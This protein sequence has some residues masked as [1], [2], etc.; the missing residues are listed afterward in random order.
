MKTSLLKKISKKYDGPKY[1]YNLNEISHSYSSLKKS[2]PTFSKLYYSMKANPNEGVVNYLH[3]LGAGIE[4]SSWGEISK[5]LKSGVNKK[6]IIFTGPAKK[7][8][9]LVQFI[10]KKTGIISIE[11]LNEFK[12]VS[13]LSKKLN[14]NI[15]CIIRINPENIDIKSSIKM[16]GVSS[17]F[18][19]D[20]KKFLQ[21]YKLF[22][23]SKTNILGFHFYSASNVISSKDLLKMFFNCIDLSLKIEKLLKIKI[24]LLNLGGGF[25]SPYGKKGKRKNYSTIKKPLETKLINS[26]GEERIKSLN[27]I[28][29]SGRYLVGT[30]GGL[31]CKVIDKKISKNKKY[32]ILDSGINNLAGMSSINRLPKLDPDIV[33]INRKE[34]KKETFDIVGP[35]CTPLDFWSRSALSYKL[36]INDIIFVPNVSSYG[37]SASLILF[38][39]HDIPN[40]LLL[41]NNKLFKTYKHY[42]NYK[43]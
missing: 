21:N 28:F 31:I 3:K 43:N 5:A 27:L 17:Q 32:I 40:E 25:A 12:R 26:F 24:K 1:V 23:S 39:S 19:I 41:L 14:K 13:S 35:L 42:L 33:L 29:E 11:S 6:N 18:G 20:S 7:N 9:E 15:D 2:L 22:N 30:C 8:E 37:L 4:C 34:K 38:L 36:K 10:K 16:M